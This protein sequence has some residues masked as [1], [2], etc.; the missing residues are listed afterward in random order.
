MGEIT[1]RSFGLLATGSLAAAASAPARAD[2]TTPPNVVVFAEPTLQPALKDAAGFWRTRTDVPVHFFGT[3]SDVMIEQ[4]VRGAR[5]DMLIATREA[6]D[7]IALP[8]KL[9]MENSRYDA[10]RNR[11]VL[12]ALGP[13][14]AATTLTPTTDLLGMLKS[15]RLAVVDAAVSPAGSAA[16]AALEKLGFWPALQTRLQGAESSPGA[17][18]LVAEG[19]APLGLFYATDAAADPRLA[20]KATVP[21]DLYPPTIYAIALMQGVATPE[22]ARFSAFLRSAE[23]QAR[24]KANGLEVL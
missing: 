11:L 1:R 5:C 16:Q 2:D 10:W 20:I 12:A 22:A 7:G 17:A 19:I 24:L 15:G 18:F 23:A 3:R 13:A 6:M 14:P 9:V 8:H 21:D 4:R